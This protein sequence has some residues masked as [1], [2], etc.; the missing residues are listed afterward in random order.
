VIGFYGWTYVPDDAIEK[1]VF[2]QIHSMKRY[3]EWQGNN[4]FF[5]GGHIMMGSDAKFF[6]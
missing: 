1:K 2:N 6:A 5:C 4:Y 3:E